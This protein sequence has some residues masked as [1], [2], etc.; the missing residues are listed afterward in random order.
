MNTAKQVTLG[1]LFACA[2]ASVLCPA[3]V[4]ASASAQVSKKWIRP[5]GNGKCD[6][7]KSGAC[8]AWLTEAA[9]TEGP[10]DG[11]VVPLELVFTEIGI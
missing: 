3:A 2:A 9:A 10:V 6:T 4:E 1:V 8:R 5:L 7:K 11:E